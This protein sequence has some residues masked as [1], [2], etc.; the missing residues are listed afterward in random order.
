MHLYDVA[1][2]KLGKSEGISL[3]VLMINLAVT[4]EKFPWKV[5]EKSLNF[6]CKFVYEPWIRSSLV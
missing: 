1:P 2:E 5:M 3:L 6:M 4:V